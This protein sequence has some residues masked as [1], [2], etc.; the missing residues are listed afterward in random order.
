MVT[1]TRRIAEPA[2]IVIVVFSAGVVLVRVGFWE[3]RGCA[4]ENNAG[5]KS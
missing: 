3:V 5:K 1:S 4:V 2:P